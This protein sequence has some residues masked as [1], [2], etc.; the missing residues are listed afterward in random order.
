MPILLRIALRNL[1]EH[2]AKSVIICG[3]IALGML[4]LVLGNSVMET[5]LAG[6]KKSFV[7]SF[8]GHILVGPIGDKGEDP[9]MFP[10]TGFNFSEGKPLPKYE[11]VFKTLNARPEIKAVNP[12]LAG[13]LSVELTDPYF[14]RG[15]F[16]GVDATLYDRMFPN[17]FEI[18]QGTRIMPDQKGVMLSEKVWNDIVKQTGIKYKIGDNLQISSFTAGG[19]KNA[20]LPLVGVF[21]FRSTNTSVELLCFI[22]VSSL[23]NLKDYVVGTADKVKIDKTDEAALDAAV[24]GNGDTFF[25]QPL[26][27]EASSVSSKPLSI[28]N[29]LGD[30]TITR[31]L[32]KPDA[33]D[34]DYLLV[35]LKDSVSIDQ[36][37][38]SLNS[39]F[40][41]NNWKIRAV[42]WQKAAGFGAS[43]ALATQLVFSFLV[44]IICVVTV[45]IIMNT[46]IVSTLE[47][48]S[49]IGT[50]RALG[51][52]KSYVRRVF[53]L[54]TMAMSVIGGLIGLAIS[55]II[56]FILN[57]AGI[58]TSNAFLQLI[59]GGKVLHPTLSI[60]AAIASAFLML[61]VGLLSSLYPTA[62]AMRVSPLKAMS[63]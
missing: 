19:V 48:T 52:Q 5:A 27:S 51:A 11:E 4:L 17:N 10:G 56:L 43:F 6:I 25:D 14:A 38:G 21:H 53:L 32:N 18:T 45:F 40:V 24:Q 16:L 2:R 26:V 30:M 47:R 29:L 12:Q 33:G 49:E 8:S 58:V 9:D 60:S 36:T 63:S 31:E 15:I 62:L 22:D 23:R 50:M 41:A 37:I 39:L 1:R 54:E 35:K 44:I 34:W 59:L 57:S 42:N 13:L 55:G 20:I 3:L 7:D 28:D 46:M 61:L